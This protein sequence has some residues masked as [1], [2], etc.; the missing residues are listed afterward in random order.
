MEID[1]TFKGYGVIVEYADSGTDFSEGD[2]FDTVD[3]FVSELRYASKVNDVD[4][5][6][7]KGDD[8]RED[9]VA[10]FRDRNIGYGV[11]IYFKLVLSYKR[12]IAKAIWKM[13]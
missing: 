10:L 8:D 6:G 9:Y 13:V 12:D 1:N 3:D 7:I 11:K 4:F 5:V 2:K